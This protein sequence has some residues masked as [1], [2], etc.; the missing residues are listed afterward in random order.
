MR[1]QANRWEQQEI[2]GWYCLM[3]LSIIPYLSDQP[4]SM[5]FSDLAVVVPFFFFLTSHHKT[6]AIL[7]THIH[8]F[9][10]LFI[11]FTIG[12][13]LGTCDGLWVNRKSLLSR[14][15]QSSDKI[16]P[17]K[18]FTHSAGGSGKRLHCVDVIFDLGLESRKG[19]Y[20]LERKECTFQ[21]KWTS[22][23]EV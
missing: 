2:Q 6:K 13:E 7:A 9:T 17:H 11:S 23:A 8:L 19:I 21:A 16:H 14:K 3:L 1:E 5:T 18:K 4:I 10:L 15:S 20:L 22:Y 12:V